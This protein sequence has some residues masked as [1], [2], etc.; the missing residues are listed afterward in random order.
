MQSGGGDSDSYLYSTSQGGVISEFQVSYNGTLTNPNGG[1]NPPQFQSGSGANTFSIDPGGQ[2]A[3]TVAQNGV[4]GYQI[5]PANGA[6][7]PAPYSPDSDLSTPS[8]G[9]AEPSGN[10]VLVI[11]AD[12]SSIASFKIDRSTGSLS[13]T[14]SLSPGQKLTTLTTD[15]YGEYLYAGTNAGVICGFKIDR[16]NGV[17]T[18]V[19]GSPFPV[20]GT[21]YGFALSAA[22]RYLYAG[23][24]TSSGP[25]IVAF[26]IQYNSGA[27]T[28]V[29]GDPYAAPNNFIGSQAIL[30]DWLTRYLWTGS[31]NP[32]QGNN[33]NSFWLYDI[34]GYTGSMNSLSEIS[35]GDTNVSYLTEGHSANLLYTAGI[36]CGPLTC[37]PGKVNSWVING[38]G[39]LEQLSGP[40]STGTPIATGIA[41]E[42][43]N[44]Q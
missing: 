33:G 11:F 2:F 35:T 26:Q 23:E 27:L 8:F 3:Y 10:F 43:G 42:R 32:G 12:Y 41:V 4:Y 17:L 20:P 40:L 38:S 18:S 39:Q 7:T 36:T 28:T 22:Y 16:N 9:Y 44:P 30:A 29:A 25:Q 31:Q 24:V 6:L 15:P 19:Q 1:G 34:D 14:A 13:Q 5:N 21:T 37:E